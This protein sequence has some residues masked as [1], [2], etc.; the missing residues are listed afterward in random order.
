MHDWTST[1]HGKIYSMIN[2]EGISLDKEPEW[3]RYFTQ[4]IL[5]KSGDVYKAIRVSD[6]IYLQAHSNYTIIATQNEK[7]L[8]CKTLKYWQDT[9]TKYNYIRVHNSY[10]V[11]QIFIAAVDSAGGQLWMHDGSKVPVSRKLK[12]LAKSL[13]NKIA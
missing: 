13:E 6:I 1:I 8:S 12:N 5:V 7:V 4:K 11:N 2:N 10:L 3:L 9:I